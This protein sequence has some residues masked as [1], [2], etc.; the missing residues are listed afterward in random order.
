M[1]VHI[2]VIW[3]HNLILQ[4]VK[5]CKADSHQTQ[6]FWN[7]MILQ[8]VG[9]SRLLRARAKMQEKYLEQYYDLYEDFHIIKLPLLEEEVCTVITNVQSFGVFPPDPC[10]CT[11]LHLIC[12]RAGITTI[13]VTWLH[14]DYIRTRAAAQMCKDIRPIQLF[15]W[16]PADCLS[17]ARDRSASRVLELFDAASP[18]WRTPWILRPGHSV[19]GKS[20]TIDTS[21][22]AATAASWQGQWHCTVIIMERGRFWWG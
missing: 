11:M 13:V 21:V 12:N 20:R 6:T 18:A 16:C 15:L 5:N 22:S 19:A 9:S 4:G 1:E 2:H 7:A 8:E 17:G 10:T 14:C 3:R